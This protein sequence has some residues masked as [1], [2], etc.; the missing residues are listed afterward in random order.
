MPAKMIKRAKQPRVQARSLTQAGR[1]MARNRLSQERENPLVMKRAG[2]RHSFRLELRR[3]LKL[4]K[5]PRIDEIS[6]ARALRR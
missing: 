6:Q 5:T 1:P 4:K 3:F 2:L